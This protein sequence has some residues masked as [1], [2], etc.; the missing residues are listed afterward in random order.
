MS[1]DLQ[2]AAGCILIVLDVVVGAYAS[3]RMKRSFFTWFFLSLLVTPLVSFVFL[4]FL[5]PEAPPTPKD[6]DPAKIEQ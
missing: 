4:Q 2:A 6:P 3:G 5:G 1:E